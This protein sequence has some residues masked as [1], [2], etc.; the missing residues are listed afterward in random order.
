VDGN[1]TRLV[2]PPVV[3]SKVDAAAILPMTGTRR[4]K[5]AAKEEKTVVAEGVSP[6]AL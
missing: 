5:Q 6:D 3:V 1:P 2:N 4:L